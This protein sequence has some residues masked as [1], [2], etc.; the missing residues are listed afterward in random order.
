MRKKE[1]EGEDEKEGDG[2]GYGEV[3]NVD[4]L[5]LLTIV[6]MLHIRC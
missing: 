5:V 3:S 6:S 4:D 1:G 2:D